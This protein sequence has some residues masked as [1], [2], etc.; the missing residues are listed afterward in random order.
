MNTNRT[1]GIVETPTRMSKTRF[2]VQLTFLAVLG[3]AAPAT[4]GTTTLPTPLTR[5]SHPPLAT[6]YGYLDIRQLKP[7]DWVQ[8]LPEQAQTRYFE[9]RESL[10][11]DERVN[12]FRSWMA[13][14]KQYLR[15]P[16]LTLLELDYIKLN[17]DNRSAS[18]Y[19]PGFFKFKGSGTPAKSQ[20]RQAR[21]STLVSMDNLLRGIRARGVKYYELLKMIGECADEIANERAQVEGTNSNGSLNRR[22][23]P[24]L[25]Q[26]VPR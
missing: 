24:G 6:V 11:G 17:I 23:R 8:G 2:I 7:E 20:E 15:D 26:S 19:E 1:A 25:W 4:A 13:Q 18:I 5:K 14:W 9:I 21:I 10:R 22:L 12:A 3:F 16:N